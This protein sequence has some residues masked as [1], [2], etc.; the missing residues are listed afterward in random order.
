[1]T[2]GQDGKVYHWTADSITKGYE[3]NKGSVHSIALRKDDAA[4]GEVALVG[5]ND[6]TLTAYK[7]DG[8]LTKLWNV[9]VDAAPRSLDLWQGKILMGLKNGSLIVQPWSADGTAAQQVIMT[10]HC[11]GEEWGLDMVELAAGDIR[12]LTSGDD[13]RILSYNVAEHKALAEG[14]VMEPPKK[15]PKK[16]KGG[17]KGGASSMASTES[18]Q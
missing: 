14:I 10:S 11:D 13:N 3:N 7:W 2:G 16:P 6:K 15:K 1:L 18:D 17:F 9:A 8:A 4:G 5:G 12:L